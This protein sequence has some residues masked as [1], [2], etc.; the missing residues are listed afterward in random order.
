MLFEWARWGFQRIPAWL[1]RWRPFTVYEI[2]LE[3]A[4]Q[5]D[6]ESNEDVAVRWASR[7]DQS[8]CSSLSPPHLFERLGSGYAALVA[9]RDDE[10]VGIVW[11]A[12]PSFVE[13]ELGVS[14]EY[15]ASDVWLFAAHVLPKHR[16]TGVYS[17]LLLRAI[18]EYSAN[19]FHRILFATTLGNVASQ[20]AHEK[21]GAQSLGAITAARIGSW[22]SLARCS[23]EVDRL[24]AGLVFGRDGIVRFRIR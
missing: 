8:K 15:L 7:E 23:G 18:D 20:H 6:V 17:Q 13:S 21:F 19:G 4:K 24:S 1:F 11:L 10:A 5:C 12:T 22:L 9:E 2:Q 3:M 14:F 16:K